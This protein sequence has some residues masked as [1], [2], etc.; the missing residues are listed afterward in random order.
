MKNKAPMWPL[1]A[2]IEML[3]SNWITIQSQIEIDHGLQ[4]VIDDDHHIDWYRKNGRTMARGKPSPALSKL[5]LLIK[6]PPKPR[7]H[8][9]L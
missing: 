7:S 5:Q 8:L 3:E 1:N 6:N 2:L 4:L 9:G